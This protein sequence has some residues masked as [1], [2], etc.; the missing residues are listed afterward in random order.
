MAHIGRT[1]SIFVQLI[2]NFATKIILLRSAFLQGKIVPPPIC[3]LIDHPYN[4]WKFFSDT[5]MWH[6]TQWNLPVH[7]EMQ[8]EL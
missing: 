1:W 4:F 7:W 2:W 6:V 3:D 8:N 5:H